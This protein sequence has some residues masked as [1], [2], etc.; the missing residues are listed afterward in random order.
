MPAATRRTRTRAT[1]R[2]CGCT[3][4]DA[5]LRY[6][7]FDPGGGRM[8]KYRIVRVARAGVPEVDEGNR[9]RPS[10]RARVRVHWPCSV[11]LVL[12]GQ[13]EKIAGAVVVLDDEK[14]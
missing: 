13:D 11:A 2:A 7:D 5:R 4:S 9:R 3:P 8:A 14:P 6:R 1:V 12:E 10:P